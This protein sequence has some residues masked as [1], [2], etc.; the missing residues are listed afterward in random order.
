MLT[1]A[2]SR[3]V[4]NASQLSLITAFKLSA[5]VGETLLKSSALVSIDHV[6]MQPTSPIEGEGGGD[7]G[8]ASQDGDDGQDHGVA[9]QAASSVH[10]ALKQTV[11]GLMEDKQEVGVSVLPGD[12]SVNISIRGRYHD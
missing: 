6:I 8:D 11:S 3:H 1:H 5:N 12:P 10:V 9:S 2:S 7:D 4:A